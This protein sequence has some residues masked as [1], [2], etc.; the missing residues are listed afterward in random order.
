MKKFLLIVAAALAMSLVG[1]NGNSEL[2]AKYQAQGEELATKL[3]AACQQQDAATIL[4]LDDSIRAIEE[5]VIAT[6]DTAAIAAYKDA[7]RDARMRNGAAISKLKVDNGEDREEVLDEVVNDAM[8]ED[9]SITTVTR[10]INAVGHKES[11]KKK[12]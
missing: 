3:D 9:V 12:K 6:G 1:C 11:P 10:S 8:N 2:K 4:A 5:E 7:L